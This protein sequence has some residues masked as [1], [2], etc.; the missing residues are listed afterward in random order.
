[1][2]L[3]NLFEAKV[4]SLLDVPE[5]ADRVGKHFNGNFNCGGEE[6]GSLEGAPLSVTGF[7]YCASNKLKS[8]EG[9]PSSVGGF[10]IAIATI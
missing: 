2:K 10:L 7:F 6:L 9:A 4:K 1:M 5:F 8:L 3:Q